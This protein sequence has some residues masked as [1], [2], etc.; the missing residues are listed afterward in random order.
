MGVRVRR[1]L[2]ER[3]LHHSISLAGRGAC[4][5][6]AH[7]WPPGGVPGPGSGSQFQGLSYQNRHNINF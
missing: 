2:G 6:H 1:R 3:S 7:E 4:L 5:C